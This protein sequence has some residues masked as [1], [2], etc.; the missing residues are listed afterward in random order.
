[1][2]LFDRQI[3]LEEEMQGLGAKRF[4]EHIQTAKEKG[5]EANTVYGME[6]AK[7]AVTPLSDAVTTYLT[8]PGKNRAVAY[9]LLQGSNPDVVAYLAV[10][11][12][13]NSVTKR[14]P[15]QR[16]AVRIAGD[17]ETELRFQLFR[18]KNKALW[19]VIKRD[20]DTRVH[21]LHRRRLILC[22]CMQKAAVHDPEL[23]WAAWCDSDKYHVGAV[24]LD[25]LIASTQL[26]E[27]HTYNTTAKKTSAKVEVRAT[28]ATLAWIEGKLSR[29]E[30]MSPLHLPMI[31]P[32]KPWT[33]PSDG[34][35]LTQV[36]ARPNRLVKSHNQNYLDELQH[37]EMPVLYSAVNAIQ[38]TPWRI[39]TAVLDVLRVLWDAGRG[40]DT[41]P[42]RLDTPL[43]PK[44]HD[45]ATNKPACKEWSRAASKVYEHNAKLQS[46]RISL[47]KMLYIA[48]K[49]S[50]E[51][52][53]YF[54]HQLD[55]RGRLYAV[56][57]Y[58]TPQGD[59]VAKGLL[60]FAGGKPIGVQ[61]VWWLKIH[62]A[63]TFG[64]DKCSLEG[65]VQW[66]D[67]HL[68]QILATAHDPLRDLWWHDADKPWQFL[69]ACLEFRGYT[70]EG[71]TYSSTLPVS[72]DGTCN[73]LQNFSAMLRDEVGGAATNLTPSDT[74]QDIYRAVADAAR[75]RVRVDAADVWNDKCLVAQRWLQFGFD[76]S[77]TK[78]PVMV[79]PY[80]GTQYSGRAYIYDHI[81]ERRVDGDVT[82]WP[83]DEDFR[84]AAYLAGHVWRAIGGVVVAA[85]SA[86]Q[87]LQVVASIAAKDGLPV[88]WTT[89]VGFPVLQAYK[90]TKSRRVNTMLGGVLVKSVLRSDLETLD[91]QRQKSS[92]S[93]NFVHSMD[94]AA[95]MLCVRRCL[96]VGLT[97]F[98]MVHD[99]YGTLAADMDQMAVCLR[100]AFVE[101][102]QHDVLE[103]FRASIVAGL[104]EEHAALVPP[105]PP[106]G[107]L[108]V[109]GVNQ[110]R[111]F[112]A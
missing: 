72:V 110:S 63:N 82:P 64:V 11:A 50:K 83:E 69:A 29:C 7:R 40:V 94:A 76:R 61:G 26:V 99:S 68:H 12:V 53:I 111:Y 78:R 4:W 45:I 55:F 97:H 9:R 37:Q 106:K 2:T 107:S 84:Y 86:M 70:L 77:A 57:S 93:P 34:G 58:L 21:S 47:C 13:L 6:L 48:E 88:H 91:A 22:H 71:V 17:I 42:A 92:I 85:V 67:D 39:N 59:D 75:L 100:T 36:T 60:T 89:P 35:Y 30:L 46:K 28:P 33:S 8:T 74:P 19:S 15:M 90:E 66:T 14:D 44:P 112:F 81:L 54:P 43:P 104:S 20:L 87:W 41:L 24:L 79:L 95:L 108:D 25:L 73:G 10:K 52:A 31:V 16:V 96:D 102:Y 1:M 3:A 105:V 56:P 32:P 98:G 80:G 23:E 49:F 18:G 5:Q 109:A 103:E 27:L 101:L 62:L 65:R 38:A 51:E